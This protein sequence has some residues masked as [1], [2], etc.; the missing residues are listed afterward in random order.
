MGPG[1]GPAVSSLVL[2]PLTN[3]LHAI[4]ISGKRRLGDARLTPGSPIKIS[5]RLAGAVTIL[6]LVGDIT[7][8]NSPEIRKTM[9]SL[10]K[11]QRVTQLLVNMTG[12]KYVDSSGIA[13]LVEG[14]KVSRDQNARFALYGLSKPARTVL[15][16]THLLRVFEVHDNEKEA[17]AAVHSPDNKLAPSPGEGAS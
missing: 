12:V 8:F 17:L 16:L 1:P 11:E 13:S 15:E 6:D 14:L 10:L 4:V 5:S 2:V 9:L 3:W 7:L